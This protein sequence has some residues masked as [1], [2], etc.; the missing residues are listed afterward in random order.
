MNLRDKIEKA[1]EPWDVSA[2]EIDAIMAAIGG[3]EP[4]FW[5]RPCCNGEMYEGPVHANSVGGKM[6]RD[7]KPGEWLPLSAAPQPSPDPASENTR[8]AVI[9]AIAE[10]LGDAY[11]CTRVWHAW[12]VGTMSQDDFVLVADQSDRLYEIAD[13]A[14]SAMPKQPSPDVAAMQSD[15]SDARSGGESAAEAARELDG[16]LRV[17]RERIAELE[18]VQGVLAAAL[19]DIESHH[20][21]QNAD[22]GRSEDRSF[23]LRT[24]RAALAQVQGQDK[25][26]HPI[27]NGTVQEVVETAQEYVYLGTPV[28][29]DPEHNCDVM[30][31]GQA[32]V[33]ARVKKVA[34][35]QPEGGS[36]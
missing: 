16:E 25:R 10:A 19:K 22:K 14:I 33:L 26:Q 24:I 35:Q 34:A 31:C 21:K 4:V 2:A 1:L 29:D 6:L 11:D 20:I 23:T 9:D 15:L 27:I 17:A 36:K 13:A 3:Q 8:Q 7:E 28:E 12:Q 30:G 18:R 32:H 5:Y